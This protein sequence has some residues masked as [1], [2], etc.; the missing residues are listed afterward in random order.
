LRRALIAAALIVGIPLL[1]YDVYFYVS[2]EWERF[3]IHTV[4]SRSRKWTAQLHFLSEGDSVPYGQQLVIYPAWS[5][6]GRRWSTVLFRGSCT[7]I[8]SLEW[9]TESELVLSCEEI[10]ALEIQLQAYKDVRIEYALLARKD[11]A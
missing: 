11:A 1:A 5:P 9:R 6:L 10:G 4:T 2:G 3:P 7:G 8:S